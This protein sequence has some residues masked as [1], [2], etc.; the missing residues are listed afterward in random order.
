MQNIENIVNILEKQKG[1]DEGSP[2][3]DQER[4]EMT[5]PELKDDDLEFK[6]DDEEDE[7]KLNVEEFI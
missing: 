6:E 5:E 1:K 3:L 7:D 2:E 4:V